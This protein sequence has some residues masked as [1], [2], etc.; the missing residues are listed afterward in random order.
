MLQ[1]RIEL[2]FGIVA[3]RLNKL[4]RDEKG[5]VNVVAIV[6]LIGVAIALA[7][8][9]RKAIGALLTDLIN[10]IRGKAETAIE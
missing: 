2:F 1:Q 7:V 9:F 10:L 3:G 5:E 6:V 8:I 4:L